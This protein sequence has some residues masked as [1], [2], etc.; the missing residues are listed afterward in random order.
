MT[1]SYFA[2]LVLSALF[3]VVSAPFLSAAEPGWKLHAIDA[4]AEYPACA[5]FDV[6]GDGKIDLI[7][8]GYWFEAPTWK[9]HFLRE[10][11]VIRG[12]FDDY[13]NLPLDVNGDGW[14]DIISVNYRSKSLFWVEHPGE[15]IKTKP[16]TSWTKRQIDTPGPMETGRLA[17]LDGDGD[18]DIVPN[19]IGFACWYEFDG[20][21][22]LKH[23]LP[24]ELAGHGIG[25]G[26]I[27]GD[28]R[29]DLVGPNGWLEAPADRVK[30]RWLWH[31]EFTLTRDASIPVLVHDVDADGDADLIWARGHRFGLYW[32]EQ[33]LIDGKREWQ[34]HA[35]DTE[36]SQFHSLLLADLDGDKQT[37]LIAGKRYLGHEGKDPGEYD[38]RGIY[39]YR[40]LPK[41]RS[42][43]R[44]VIHDGDDVA[45][46][47]DPKIVDIDG[48]G[49]LD[50]VTGDRSGFYLLENL[51][52]EEALFS[53][54]LS[55]P[56]FNHQQPLQWKDTTGQSQV[57]KTPQ[58]WASRKAEIQTGMEKAMGPLPTPD[59]RIPLD[60]KIISMEVT[61]DY[62]RVKLTYASE[63]GDR[64]PAYLLVPKSV[65][66]NANSLHGSLVD[67]QGKP[68]PAM[69]CLHPTNKDGKLQ[70]VGFVGL[71]TR[72]YGHQLAQHGFV[73]VVPDYPSFGDYV[74]YD[75]H[76][77]QPG[78][79]K[80]LYVSGT[81]KAIWTNIRAVDLLESLG[82]VDGERIGAIGHSLGGHNALYTAVF[83]PRLR[84]VVTSCGF[85]GFHDYYGGK[86]AGWT[87][88]RYMPRIRDAYENNPDKM[89]FDFHEVLAAIAPRSVFVAAPLHDANF[90]NAGVRKVMTS[91]G[92]VYELL[93]AN[94]K[95]QAIYPDCAHD[96]PDDVRK[97]VYDWLTKELK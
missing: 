94:S 47:L 40:F 74:D 87:S 58:E 79:D 50:I 38:A 76:Q 13:S 55:S 51:P 43:Q 23:D 73:C 20:G 33:Q 67:G 8:G 49:D 32:H 89:P 39:S 5:A 97:Q 7:N 3:A 4:K 2:R 35:I 63:P 52:G 30:D 70:T 56:E 46:G 83:E 90:D 88:D 92:R 28:K 34:K 54:E 86:L 59:R 69:L 85:T 82:Y 36:H 45:F 17:D 72:H 29:L 11:E 26:D 57:I 71:P 65:K 80:P 21:K 41:T 18:P 37:E 25:V 75:F 14:T 22:F 1:S 19:C 12:R 95:L 53:V 6:N 96:F 44:T 15:V 68:L 42:W 93:G 9:K 91:A 81:M 77:K 48:D 10:V 84:A 27:N 61:P 60:V 78:S 66:L 64:T 31:P 62:T 24:I 16:A